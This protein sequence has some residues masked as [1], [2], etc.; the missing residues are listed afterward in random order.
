MGCPTATV[1]LPRRAL[2]AR[3][4][5]PASLLRLEPGSVLVLFHVITFFELTIG[6]LHNKCKYIQYGYRYL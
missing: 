3:G 4:A 1:C 6:R 5:A 2:P